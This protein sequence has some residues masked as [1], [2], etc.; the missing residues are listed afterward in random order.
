MVEPILSALCDATQRHPDCV[1]VLSLIGPTEIVRQYEEA[2]CPV[3]EDP[4]RA[5]RAVSALAYLGASFDR[6]ASRPPETGDVNQPLPDGPFSEHGAS[7]VLAGAGLPMAEMRLVT[8][9][10][11][12]VEAAVTAG[13]PVAMKVC[14]RDVVHKTEIGGVALDVSDAHGV[15]TTFDRLAQAGD[16]GSDGGFE[17]ILL[18]PMAPPGIDMVVG[19]SR[20][21]SFGPM[22]MV[23]FGGTL[24]EVLRDVSFR[25]PPIDVEEAKRMIGE[26][27]GFPILAGTRGASPYDV[28]AL[29][30]A[31]V[32]LSTFAARY[33]DDLESAEINPLRVLPA[34]QGAVGLDAVVITRTR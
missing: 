25:L 32:Q 30:T 22:L 7:Q 8:T 10:D 33:G 9:A 2:G 3:F 13:F 15:R 19:V 24:V 23:G 4:T 21:A 20:D 16:A 18:G 11:Q 31:L 5:V 27:R 12:A 17:G 1:L 29:T 34:G 28:D 6:P 26:L 14:S